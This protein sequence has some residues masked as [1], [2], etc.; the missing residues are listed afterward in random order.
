MQTDKYS[1]YGTL[2]GL[3]GA[4]ALLVA[5]AHFPYLFHLQFA[6]HDYLAVDFF[7][8]LSGFVAGSAY[9]SKLASGSLT[10][11]RY[12]VLRV[13]RLY[14]LYI[15]GIALGAVA[16]ALRLP[17]VY[18]PL[19]GQAIP[20]SIV[21]MPSHAPMPTFY[22]LPYDLDWFF[23]LDFPAWSLFF[24]LVASFV[25]GL[26]FRYLSTLRLV[27][28]LCVCALGLA[29]VAWRHNGYNLGPYW[30][31]YYAGF[32][33]VGYA[34]T[35]GL[36][37]YRFRGPAHVRSGAA[38]IAVV[39]LV[40]GMLAIPWRAMEFVAFDLLLGLVV[41]P[42]AVWVASLVEPSARI[43][44]FFAFSGRVSY[45]VYVLHVPFG[46][47][48][49]YLA[50]RFQVLNHPYEFAATV[51]IPSVV[52][53]TWCANRYYDAPVRRALRSLTRNWF[54]PRPVGAAHADGS[55]SWP[56]TRDTD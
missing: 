4:A 31:G 21:M 51:L 41:L 54:A 26:L 30:P 43:T 23:P 50:V 38:S 10:W 7:F 40:I 14:P 34:F 25:Y 35:V 5:V 28:I 33:R 32:L 52:L 20:A 22:P 37:V 1:R 19:I 11:R 53:L 39:L 45:G 49:L 46:F 12:L 2:D 55:L 15:A 6:G 24:E 8:A 56:A 29:I 47:I 13:I 44:P 16:L 42:V 18:W 17:A 36:L 27:A 3:R 9:D 48:V